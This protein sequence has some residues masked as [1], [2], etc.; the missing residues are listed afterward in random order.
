MSVSMQATRETA[1]AIVERINSD[2]AFKVQVF[3]DPGSALASVGLSN[4]AIAEFLTEELSDKGSEDGVFT[5]GKCIFTCI[6]TCV[7][8]AY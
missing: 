8:S 6:M 5:F 1:A 3:S 2:A 4:Y 7:G